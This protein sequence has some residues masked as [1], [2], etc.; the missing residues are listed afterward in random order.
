MRIASP[1]ELQNRC[2]LHHCLPTSVC[3]VGCVQIER[4]KR[5]K[6]EGGDVPAEVQE[7]HELKRQDGDAPVVVALKAP[8]ATA[9]AP[10]V[11]AKPPQEYV[12]PLRSGSPRLPVL[13][14]LRYSKRCSVLV[15]QERQLLAPP[16]I[17]QWRRR[18]PGITALC[19]TYSRAR[20]SRLHS[21]GVAP[22]SSDSGVVIG[23]DAHEGC[24]CRADAYALLRSLRQ[25]HREV[26]G[27][28]GAH[29]RHSCCPHCHRCTRRVFRRRRYRQS[30]TGTWACICDLRVHDGTVSCVEP[31]SQSRN[32]QVA[33]NFYYACWVDCLLR[34]GTY[35]QM[36]W[37]CCLQ[38]PDSQC[39]CSRSGEWQHGRSS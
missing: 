5:A 21:P 2:R 35:R 8:K 13:H 17:T 26:A 27:D 37:Q 16:P 9:Q 1:P 32:Q 23:L 14:W 15:V 36:G 24:S 34:N 28:V 38:D 11:K 39:M 30:N 25:Q 10:A 19:S 6:L 33:N 22:R 3:K 20:P 4:A 18:H 31:I 29:V 12:I 7:D